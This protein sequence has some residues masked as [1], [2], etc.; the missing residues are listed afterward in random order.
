MTLNPSVKKK[1]NGL[2]VGCSEEENA[3]NLNLVQMKKQDRE[4]EAF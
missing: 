2:W 1:K 4:G 3:Q